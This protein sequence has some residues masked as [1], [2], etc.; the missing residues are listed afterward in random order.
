VLTTDGTPFAPGKTV[1]VEATVWAYSSYTS[2]R[3]DLYYTANA[4][5]PTW[6][7]IG[8]LSPTKAGAQTLSATYTLPTG[9][10]QAVR[11]QFRYG[12]SAGTCTSGS[13]ND[14]DDLIFA[15]SP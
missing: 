7:F 8:T 14:R 4:N 13:Y 5:S 2:D 9:T 15:V 6:T 12:G 3:L 11:A 10:L 1:R